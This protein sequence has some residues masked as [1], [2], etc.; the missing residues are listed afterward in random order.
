MTDAEIFF[1]ARR[2]ALD[3]DHMMSKL[4]DDQYSR[5]LSITNPTRSQMIQQIWIKEK[6]NFL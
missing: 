2:A 5:I 1:Y 4:T 3:F 6:I